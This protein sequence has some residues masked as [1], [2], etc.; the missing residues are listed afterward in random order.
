MGLFNSSDFIYYTLFI[1]NHILYLILFV[2]MTTLSEACN[3]F[4]VLDNEHKGFITVD[5]FITSFHN[6]YQDSNVN[7]RDI[8]ENVLL[9]AM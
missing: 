2:E 9:I 1:S 4:N 7:D 8:H 6:F 5:K 3:I